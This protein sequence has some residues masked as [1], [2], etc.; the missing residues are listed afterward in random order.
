L[1][2]LLLTLVLCSSLALFAQGGASLQQNTVYAGA[3]GKFESDADTVMIQFNINAQDDTA[4]AA[5]DR[6]SRAAEQI[7]QIMRSNG[8]DPKQA[9]ISFFSIQ[10]VYDWHTNKQTLLAYQVNSSVSLK[11]SDFSKVAPIT[12][13]LTEIDITANQ[14]VSYTLDNIDAAKQKAIADAYRRAR[15]S[16]EAVAKAGGRSLG[17]MIYASVDT[18]EPVRM[19]AQP[20]PRVAMAKAAPAPTAEF[21][22]QKVTVTAHVNA[23]F[24]LK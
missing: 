20:M 12:Q 7:R 13:Q 22:P 1:K 21:T 18:F 2:S 5:Y 4:K 10:P 11:I 9:E 19:F 23:A 16:A 6:A 14:S 3:D 8:I 24:V 15:E 17:E